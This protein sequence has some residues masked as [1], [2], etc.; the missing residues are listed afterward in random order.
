MAS[1]PPPNPTL[2]AL[3]L[4]FFT[5]AEQQSVAALRPEPRFVLPQAVDILPGVREGFVCEDLSEETCSR[6]G[7][8]QQLLAAFSF[9]S[10]KCS[11]VLL[12]ATPL[13]QN[14]DAFRWTGME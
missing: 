1:C 9:F 12:R 11:C 10:A 14:L 6:Y 2:S 4:I 13:R 8:Q 5:K 7:K 3:I